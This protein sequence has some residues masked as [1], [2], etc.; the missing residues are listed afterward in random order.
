MLLTA[1]LAG[2]PTPR[3]VVL[4]GGGGAGGAYGA[5]VQ[6]LNWSEGR[7]VGLGLTHYAERGRADYW[8]RTFTNRQTTTLE[9]SMVRLGEGGIGWRPWFSGGLGPAYVVVNQSKLDC[10]GWHDCATI[11]A[12]WAV[13]WAAH[14]EAAVMLRPR[15]S[16]GV[17][18]ELPRFPRNRR[19]GRAGFVTGVRLEATGRPGLMLG[20]FV[21][22]GRV[23]KD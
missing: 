2:T 8:R 10:I 21:S 11:P 1:A 23:P 12:G 19:R 6:L 9:L 13:T 3:A 15:P 20:A 22:V 5:A 4:G 17:L 16:S 18:D 14:A 7:A